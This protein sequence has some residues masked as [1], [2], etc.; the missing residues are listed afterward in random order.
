MATGEHLTDV[1]LQETSLSSESLVIKGCRTL[2]PTRNNYVK[3]VLM[4]HTI[5]MTKGMRKIQMDK[6]CPFINFKEFGSIFIFWKAKFE[7]R[8]TCQLAT[9]NF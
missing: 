9:T 4:H 7:Q 6:F 1:I 3:S 2:L 5:N 8:K